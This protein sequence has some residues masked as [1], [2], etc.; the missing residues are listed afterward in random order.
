M[1]TAAAASHTDNVT[2]QQSVG[3]DVHHSSTEDHASST[4]ITSSQ[5]T[6]QLLDQ[7]ETSQSQ[8]NLLTQQKPWQQGIVET[9]ALQ[10]SQQASSESLDTRKETKQAATSERNY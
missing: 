10:T 8:I 3:A 4:S 5:N 9:A 6:S 7:V 2:L 1:A